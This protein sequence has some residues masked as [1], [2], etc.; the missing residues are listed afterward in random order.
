V[1]KIAGISHARA[2]RALEEVGF[3]IVREGHAHSI[4]VFGIG[5]RDG[6]IRDSRKRRAPFYR[7]GRDCN[8]PCRRLGS[9]READRVSLH[10]GVGDPGERQVQYLGAYLG[11]GDEIAIRVLSDEE[12]RAASY[13]A[14]ER[15]S[16]CGSD[17]HSVR[18]LVAGPEVAICDSCLTA[19][20]A[21]LV[22]CAPLP[23][24][25]FIHEQ[26]DAHC[27]FCQKA[28]PDV[29]GLFVRNAAGVCPE[30]LRACVEITGVEGA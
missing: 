11:P 15:C 21:V 19:F 6:G 23:I 18:S 14:P 4:E 16:F 8:H 13:E 24:G 27:G 22:S 9:R 7:R 17:T 30:C 20:H 26:G 12:S 2:V 3:R 1:A 25:A 10:V 28:P 5:W 29:P